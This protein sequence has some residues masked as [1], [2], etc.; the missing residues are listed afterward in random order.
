MRRR[1]MVHLSDVNIVLLTTRLVAWTANR[2]LSFVLKTT[3]GGMC[4]LEYDNIV[5]LGPRWLTSDLWARTLRY[6]R[7]S[8]FLVNCWPFVSTWSSAE[9]VADLRLGLLLVTILLP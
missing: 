5:V 7:L 1:L 9:P 3:L 8:R 4:E 2:L 6:G